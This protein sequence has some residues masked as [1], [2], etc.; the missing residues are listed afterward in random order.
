MNSIGMR[1]E[2]RINLGLSSKHIRPY[3][4]IAIEMS[5]SRYN[6]GRH[7]TSNDL[8]AIANHVLAFLLTL[9]FTYTMG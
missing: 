2:F 9:N 6:S 8:R 5:P 7:L 1:T 3:F 4:S